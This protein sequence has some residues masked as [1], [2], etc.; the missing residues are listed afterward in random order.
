MMLLGVVMEVVMEVVTEVKVVV[1][2]MMV[3]GLRELKAKLP[4]LAKPHS[5]CCHPRV[6]T[7]GVTCVPQAAVDQATDARVAAAFHS[8]PVPALTVTVTVTVVVP[9]VAV[10]V[11]AAAAVVVECRCRTTRC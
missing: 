7:L 3:E 5:R 9:A 4:P 2:L 11:A 1:V 10:V 8:G 6:T